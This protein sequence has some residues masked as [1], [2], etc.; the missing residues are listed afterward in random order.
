MEIESLERI[1]S[2][3]PFFAGLDDAISASS[4]AAAPRTCA[5]RPASIC[6]TR[7]SRPTR[8]YL[9][10]H[11]RVALEIAAPGRG[12]DDLPDLGE[13]EIV[14][15]SWLIPPYRWTLRRPGAGADPR[16][17]HGR[18]L[19]ARQMRGRPRSRLR[20]DEALRAGPG[21]AAAG[22]PAAD[23]RCLWHASADAPWRRRRRPDDAARRARAPAPARRAATSGRSTSS[24]TATG[25]DAVR[26]GPVQHADLFGV[27][28]VPISYQRRPGRAGTG[29]STRSAPSAPVSTRARRAASRATRS[30]CAVPSASAGR[31]TEA[32]GATWSSSPAGS[33]S[34]RC[35]RRSTTC[36]PSASA[37]AT[38]RCSTAR[39]ARTTSCSAASSN[40]GG[41]GSTSTSR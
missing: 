33:A 17:R 32:A 13:G 31:S 29:W 1:V 38:S 8:F 22:D 6:S 15:V 5:S 10:R 7:A 16:D 19:P 37:T 34:R 11:G 35:G 3:H 20:D 28:E 27:G 18:D 26:A 9:I 21:R 4:S 25:A 23:P 14:G 12:A 36:W 30:A 2:E 24:R 40:A 39:A 41:A